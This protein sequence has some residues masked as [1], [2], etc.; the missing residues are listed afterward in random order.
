M[1]MGMLYRTIIVSTSYVSIQCERIYISAWASA[2][3][4]LLSWAMRRPLCV[5]RVTGTDSRAFSFYTTIAES[6]ESIGNKSYYATM[7][8]G[9][10][11]GQRR[12]ALDKRKSR[13]RISATKNDVGDLEHIDMEC[14]INADPQERCNEYDYSNESS[15]RTGQAS[16]FNISARKDATGDI[17]SVEMDCCIN[18][19]SNGADEMTPSVGGVRK[20]CWMTVLRDVFREA[21]AQRADQAYNLIIALAVTVG[22]FVLQYYDV[23]SVS[24]Y[25]LEDNAINVCTAIAG[26]TFTALAL[27]LPLA[28]FLRVGCVDYYKSLAGIFSYTILVNLFTVMW[29]LIMSWGPANCCCT[30]CAWTDYALAFLLLYSIILVCS[31]TLHCFCVHTFIDPK[32]NRL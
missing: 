28:K 12:T 21:W 27:I 26:L 11:N 13:F 23:V 29:A 18:S 25:Q 15:S 5:G 24:F 30:C 7:M 31:A 3:L 20:K 17:S 9:G 22:I 8:N 2:L 4:V 6:G 32:N 1:L 14:L 19:G 16:S 10:E